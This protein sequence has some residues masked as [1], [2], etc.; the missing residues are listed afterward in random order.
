MHYL[1]SCWQL[2]YKQGTGLKH[3][4]NVHYGTDKRD[5]DSDGDDKGL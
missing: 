2:L 3:D 4:V 1:P 5:N